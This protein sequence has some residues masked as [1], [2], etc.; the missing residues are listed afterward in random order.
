MSKNSLIDTSSAHEKRLYVVHFNLRKNGGNLVLSRFSSDLAALLNYNIVEVS[1]RANFVT[2]LTL[3]FSRELVIFSNPIL[4]LFF[5]LKKRAVHF[6]Q[7]VDENL[8]SAEDFGYVK[9]TIFRRLFLISLYFSRTSRVFNSKLT[10]MHYKRFK[11]GLGVYKAEHNLYFK[12]AQK[13]ENKILSKNPNQCVWIGTLHHRKGFDDVLVIAQN[14]PNF[15]F[16]CIVSGGIAEFDYLPQNVEIFYNLDHIEVMKIIEI[17]K[18]SIITSSFES[19]SLPIYEGLLYQNKVLAKVSK[20][21][22]INGIENYVTTYSSPSEVQ[23]ENLKNRE[24]FAF[25]DPTSDNL[26]LTRAIFNEI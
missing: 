7:S 8:F 9:A 10:E 12:D 24:K 1:L 23:L 6:V 14:S 25:K 11:R 26:I 20:Y 3:I 16:K 19:L 4:L 13:L 5:F 15:L 18:I 17:S 2:V 22:S 21:L